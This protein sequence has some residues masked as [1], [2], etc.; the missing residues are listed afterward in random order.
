MLGG[1][2]LEWEWPQQA[3]WLLCKAH[4]FVALVLDSF[5]PR[6]S[7]LFAATRGV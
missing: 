1:D 3:R 4:A 6:G 7:A 5:A 2:G